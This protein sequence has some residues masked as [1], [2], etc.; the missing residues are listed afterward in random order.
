MVQIHRKEGWT[1]NPKDK[2]VNC[3]LHMVENN[4]GE[5]PCDNKSDDKH[6]PCSDYREKDICHCGLYVKIEK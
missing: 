1:L 4:D 3:I 6:C 2:V 5:C